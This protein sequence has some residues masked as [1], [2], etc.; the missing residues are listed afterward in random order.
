[1][2]RC[3]VRHRR[4]HRPPAGS[5]GRVGGCGM[6]AAGGALGTG[7]WCDGQAWGSPRGGRS[8]LRA[9][10]KGA[11]VPPGGWEAHSSAVTA[12]GAVVGIWRPQAAR[13]S[14]VP[15]SPRHQGWL[16]RTQGGLSGASVSGK[17]QHGHSSV[18]ARPHPC[19]FLWRILTR[20]TVTVAVTACRGPRHDEEW[21]TGGSA[22]PAA[23]GLGV[24]AWCLRSRL[25]HPGPPLGEPVPRW[26][27]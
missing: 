4:V 12:G 17:I 9:W 5:E 25:P 8:L 26:S 3:T 27:L 6:K 16:L 7:S 24:R 13:V 10:W 20:D 11:S 14:D 15:G 18:H 19:G 1:M 21:G 23:S 2:G 22:H